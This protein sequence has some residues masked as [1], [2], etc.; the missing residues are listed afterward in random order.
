MQIIYSYENYKGGI[1]NRCVVIVI[2]GY[3]TVK[4]FKSKE[5]DKAYKRA[6]KF[7]DNL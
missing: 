5:R 7:L 4:V 2:D 6:E 1:N 3:S